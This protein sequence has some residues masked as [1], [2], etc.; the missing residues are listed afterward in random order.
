MSYH[1]DRFEYTCAVGHTNQFDKAYFASESDGASDESAS[2]K[3]PSELPC[4][5]CN[6]KLV[7]ASLVRVLHSNLSEQD[8]YSFQDNRYVESAAYHEAGH[9]VIA[10]VQ[11]IPL[12]DHGIHI[13]QKGSGFAHFKAMRPEGSR[14]LGGEA[15]REETIR[16]AQAGYIAQ[17]RFYLRFNDRLPPSGAHFDVNDINGLVEEMYSGRTA[18]EEAKVRLWNEAKQ[19]VEN[20][21]G[22]IEALAQALLK[23]EWSDQAPAL[24]ERRWSTQLREKKM[25][26]LEVVAFLKERQ[27]SASLE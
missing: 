20:R 4:S 16:S 17:E 11:Q 13:D 12:K 23:K 24:G 7:P 27:I 19:L 1:L 2:T 3:L 8:F 22:V 25:E 15:R 10:A 18:C 14:N 5:G 21:W 6:Y 26:G 9:I